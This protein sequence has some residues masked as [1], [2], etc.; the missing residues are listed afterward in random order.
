MQENQNSEYIWDNQLT[1]VQEKKLQN[2]KPYMIV[3]VCEGRNFKKVL[4][5][6]TISIVSFFNQRPFLGPVS[7]KSLNLSGPFRVT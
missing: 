1:L 3:T 6:Y 2:T 4:K 5:R 7:R